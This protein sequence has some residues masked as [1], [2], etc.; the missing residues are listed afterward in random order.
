MAF[1][2]I[3]AAHAARACIQVLVGA[4]GSEVDIVVVHGQLDV[5]NR[6]CKIDA[7]RCANSMPSGSDVGHRQ[8]LT[9]VVLHTWQKHGRQLIATGFDCMDDVF[10]MQ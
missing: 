1:M 6:V 9:G 10:G 3:D 2:H 4:P 8:H 5:A 7:D